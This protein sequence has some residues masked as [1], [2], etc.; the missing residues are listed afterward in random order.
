MREILCSWLGTLG[1]ALQV[2]AACGP[3]PAL[4]A[5]VPE[6][7]CAS[8]VA[9]AAQGFRMPRTVLWLG[10]SGDETQLLVAD[11]GNWEPNRGRLLHVRVNTRDGSATTREVLA[12]LDRPHGL[13]KGPD[14]RIYLGEAGRISRFAWPPA[15]TLVPEPVIADLP[16]QGRHPLKEFAFGPD[17]T[18]WINVGA[19]SDAC[20]GQA[21]VGPDGRPACPDMAG[22]R[23]QAA[24]YRARWRWPRGELID[25]LP[26]ATGLRNS[27]ALAVHPSGQV[28][29]AENNVDL[30]DPAFPAEEVNRLVQGGHYGWP[31]CVQARRPLPG[32]EAAACAGTRAPVQA[33]PAH[34]APLQMRYSRVPGDAKSGALGLLVSW[35]GHRPVGRRLVRYEVK[36]DGTPHGKPTPV[37]DEWLAAPGRPGAPVGWA[38]DGDS[39]LWI[40]DDRNRMI[41]WL[42]RAPAR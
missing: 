21:G 23:P 10:T 11:M 25:V 18:L 3:F 1:V 20:E 19:S 30:D 39:G 41:V 22:P 27:M 14:G 8:V 31:G 42:R 33:M 17:G 6:G 4:Q 40:A 35:H 26:F 12:R 38:E 9:T 34:A 32:F 29:Q 16:A 15:G 5:R 7:W 24:V 37:I 28:F 13:R 2:G 36:A